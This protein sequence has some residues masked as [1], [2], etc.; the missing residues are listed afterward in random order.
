MVVLEGQFFKCS[1]V[2]A[3]PLHVDTLERVQ[4]LLVAA[5]S[6]IV[7]LEALRDSLGLLHVWLSP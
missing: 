5:Q 3:R 6:S 7:S 2:L 1:T 4:V